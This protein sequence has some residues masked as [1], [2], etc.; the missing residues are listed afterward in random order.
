ML[1]FVGG[2]PVYSQVFATD[3]PTIEILSPGDGAV[4]R[5]STEGPDP[6]DES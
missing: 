1:G 5:T 4:I 6:S 3:K 2:Y